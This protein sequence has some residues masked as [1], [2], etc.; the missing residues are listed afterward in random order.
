[1]SLWSSRPFPPNAFQYSASVRVGYNSHSI[2][3]VSEK[4]NELV[5]TVLEH[6]NLYK[7][8]SKYNL[9]EIQSLKDFNLLPIRFANDFKIQFKL[10]SKMKA[11]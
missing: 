7:E 2:Y 4:E 8:S 6:L 1:M 9:S 10:P 3:I 5:K 11:Q